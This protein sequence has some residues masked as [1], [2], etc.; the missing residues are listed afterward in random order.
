M[1]HDDHLVPHGIAQAER[2]LSGHGDLFDP[3][4]RLILRHGALPPGYPCH[5]SVTH[6]GG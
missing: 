5:D 6:G 3:A 2:R 4:H 1:L